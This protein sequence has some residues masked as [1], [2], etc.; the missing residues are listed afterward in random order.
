MTP[1]PLRN[2]VALVTGAGGTM[3]RAVVAALIEDGCRVAL[4]DVNE[5]SLAPLVATYGGAVMAATCDISDIHA[6]R[7]AHAL[8]EQ[9]LGGVDIL[10]NNAGILSNNKIEATS[11]TEWRRVLGANLDGAMFWAQAVVPGMKARRFGRIINTSS[12]AA[13]TGGLTAGTAYSVSKGA[14]GSMIE[15]EVRIDGNRTLWNR[16]D[17]VTEKSFLTRRDDL[18]DTPLEGMFEFFDCGVNSSRTFLV[19]EMKYLSSATGVV[20]I[21]SSIGFL[22]YSLNPL[23][24]SIRSC[25]QNHHRFPFFEYFLVARSRCWSVSCHLEKTSKETLPLI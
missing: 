4:V 10:I 15:F 22:R 19:P 8:V 3:G 14:M 18:Q 17:T 5:A 12:L 25:A 13:K 20:P 24:G 2:K 6:V 16:S 23:F 7:A 11:D 21:N 1:L 9:R